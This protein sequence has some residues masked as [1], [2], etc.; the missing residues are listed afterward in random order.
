MRHMDQV[1][2]LVAIFCTLFLGSMVAFAQEAPPTTSTP[3]NIGKFPSH[4]A[5]SL[6]ESNDTDK[7]PSASA[8]PRWSSGFQFTADTALTAPSA[9]YNPTTN[10]MI[11]FAGLNWG[12]QAKDTNAVLL[13]TPANS[14]GVWSTLIANGAAG[15]PAAR[16]GH[17]AVY[18][19]ATNRM[20]VFGGGTDGA[21]YF[22][23]VW[24]LTNADGQGGAA[25]WSQLTPSGPSPDTRWLHTAVYDSSSNRMIVF[26]GGNSSQT[27]SDVWVLSNANGLGGPP[28]WTQLSPGGSSPKGVLASS[29]VY[30]PVNNIMTI[31]GGENLARTAFTNG[32]WTLSHANGLGGAPQWTNIVADNAPGSPAKRWSH[33]AAYDAA[34][35]RMTVFGGGSF[36]GPSSLSGFNDVWVVSSANGLGGPPTW[37]KLAATGLKPGPRGLHT[38]VYD[39][40]NNRMMVF[41]GEN[42][43]A[44]YYVTWVLSHANGL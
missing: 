37:T 41:G 36:S 27:F 16:D 4:M 22:S 29:A 39:T 32:V 43:D 19:S 35:N 21:P 5:E 3:H 14:N 10:I 24:V 9:V 2:T 28:T 11:V 17:S 15:S 30:D 31:F 1:R 26:G 13:L 7:A 18:D 44:V 8:K 40:V 38:A 12:M 34:S 23:D 20:I 25:T 33:S 42:A 6:A